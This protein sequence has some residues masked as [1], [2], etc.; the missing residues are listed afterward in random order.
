MKS[1]IKV[2]LVQEAPVFFDKSSTI[3]KMVH[4]INKSGEEGVDLMIFPESYIPGY[5]RGFTFGSDI[6]RRTDEGKDLFKKYWKES[7][8]IGGEE[9]KELESVSKETGVYIVGGITERTLNS[10]SLYCTTIYISPI[11]GLMGIHRKIKPTAAERIVWAEGDGST[12]SAFST[13]LGIMGGLTCWE[14]YMPEA[15]MAMYRHGVQLYIA[16]TAD[17]RPEWVAT[18]QHIALEGRCYVISCN[19][20]VNKSDIPVEYHHLLDDY[21]ENIC[22]GGSLVVAPDGHIISGPV[23]NCSELIYVELDMDNV[24]RSKLDFDPNGHYSRPDIFNLQ[25]QNLPEIYVESNN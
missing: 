14:N 18:M 13:K 25:I 16:P 6:G 11:D 2:C 7:I 12:M 10:G 4:H 22:K 20:H 24:I 17:S 9:I 1:Q 5:P 8:D 21:P 15:R 23:Y 19:Q 3:K